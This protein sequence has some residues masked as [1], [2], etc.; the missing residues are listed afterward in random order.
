[1]VFQLT[2]DIVF[3]HPSLAD[4]SGLLAIGGDLSVERLELAYEN[5]I[6][7]WY[8]DDDPIMWYSPK[9]RFVLFPHKLMISKSMK[10][11]MQSGKFEIRHDTAFAEVIGHCKGVVREGQ[12]GTW[13]TGEMEQAYMRLHQY[14]MAH[15]V[16]VF[17]NNQLVGGLY[18][19][20]VGDVFCGESM[21][22][23]VS[24]ASKAALIWLCQ[25]GNF[26]LVDCQIET[27]HLRTMGA[28]LIPQSE[29]LSI[30]KKEA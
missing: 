26:R 5:G 19:V 14:G 17:E 8:S 24:N 22:S 9:E 7:P 27:A 30:L 12:D 21:F 18:G 11:I 2:D 6:F 1:M 23:L 3:P 20:K 13:I 4:D 10:R 29:Y 16:E 28:E 25:S 15:S